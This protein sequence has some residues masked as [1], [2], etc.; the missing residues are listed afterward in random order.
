[1][2]TVWKM[3]GTFKKYLAGDWMNHHRLSRFT[4]QCSWICNADWVEPPVVRTQ[5]YNLKPD[6]MDS[7]VIS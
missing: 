1:M 3:A 6:K 5:V 4:L 7:H 2:E